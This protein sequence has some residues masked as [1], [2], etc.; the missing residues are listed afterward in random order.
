[1]ETTTL[2][3]LKFYFTLVHG[4]HAVISLYFQ[5]GNGPED[6]AFFS[7]MIPFLF[8][9]RVAMD[10]IAF[11][12]GMIPRLGCNSAVSLLNMDVSKV[13]WDHIAVMSRCLFDV[14]I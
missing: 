8:T 2:V 13:L 1:M 4:P 14:Y 11:F 9:F 6:I 5:S 3:L 10:L 12:S 7:G